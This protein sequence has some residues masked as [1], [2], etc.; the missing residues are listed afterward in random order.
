MTIVLR[1]N[2]APRKK[3][4]RSCPLSG[5]AL[6]GP[7][8]T[9]WTAPRRVLPPA[10]ER[11]RTNRQWRPMS[12][13]KPFA[14]KWALWWVDHPPNHQSLL[15]NIHS[16]GERERERERKR[17]RD[18]RT[19]AKYRSKRPPGQGAQASPHKHIGEPTKGHDQQEDRPQQ[20]SPTPC[21]RGPV[22]S[23]LGPPLC[24][25]MKNARLNAMRGT[26]PSSCEQGAMEIKVSENSPEDE[27]LG[28][29][30]ATICSCHDPTHSLSILLDCIVKP[31]WKIEP[32]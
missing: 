15:V 32:L 25:Q 6:V 4:C 18:F 24:T 16:S 21:I 29:G 22:F 10:R 27:P 1:P 28:R 14:P 23:K 11:N 20:K 3:S 8:G 9:V 12:R 30:W 13:K 7:E 5:V 17:E 26:S 19:P 31:W 2:G